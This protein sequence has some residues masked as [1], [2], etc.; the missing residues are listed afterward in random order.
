M[1]KEKIVQKRLLSVGFAIVAGVGG[2]LSSR[3]CG[4]QEQQGKVVLVREG[5]T[6]V[7][8]PYAPNI[9]R[10]TL[11]TLYDRA[12]AG[13]GY[14]F[15]A[16][17]AAGGW[18]NE[19]SGDA[20]VYRSSRLTVSI[21][22]PRQNMRPIGPSQKAIGD[23][24]GSSGS[25]RRAPTRVMV[26][27]SDGATLVNML[28]WFMNPPTHQ[29]GNTEILADQRPTD[30]PFYEVGATFA[31]PDDEHY[32]GLGQNQEGR[33][34]HRGQEVR[35]WSQYNAAGGESWCVPLLVT[36]KGYGILWDNS[37][38]TTIEPGFN[39]V[40]Q[41]SSE[42]GDRVSFFVIAGK[43]TDEIYS[44]YRLL[45][46]AT[47]LLPKGA[48]GFI[49]SKQRYSTQDE[50]LAVA[51]G[52]RERHLPADVLV[53]DWFYYTKM[54][55]MDFD[56]RYWPDPA[57]MN[58][59][60][61]SM[62]FQTMI[63]VW[64]RFVP[65]SRYYD[66][67]AKNGWLIHLADGTPM[68]TN[69]LPENH[70]GANIDTTNPDAGKFLWD[71]IHQNLIAKGFTS[72]WTDETEPDIPPNGAYLHVGPGTEYFNV[73]PLFHT[74]AVYD[75]MR[76]DMKTR[77]LILARAAYT[78][79]Q[80]NGTIF[81]SSDISPTWD[82]LKRQVP[83]GLDATASGLPYWCN[84]VGGFQGLPA[85]HHPA[86]PPLIDPSDA[87]GNVGD[88]DDYPELYVRWYEYGAFEPIFRTHGTRTYN[89][90][91]SYGKQAEPILEKYL[92]L[93]YQLMPY[94][95]SLAWK[96]YSTGAPYTRALFMNFPSD[97]KVAGLGDEYMFG[98]ALLVAPVTDQGATSRPVYLPA[99]T[100]WYNYWTNEKLH[101]GQTIEADAPIDTIPLF[102]K[103]GSILPLGEAVESTSQPQALAKI[104]IYPGSDGDFALYQ[105]DG[106]TY[107]YE[108]S[109]GQVT[110]LHWIDGQQR[111]SHSGAAAWSGPDSDLL[112]IVHVQSQ[113]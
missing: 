71:A 62:G 66:Q 95:Y 69:G 21:P 47:P 98:P 22:M 20:D 13:P 104:R 94:I 39:E 70:T 16:L 72:I 43:D 33:L 108:K 23:F 46:G 28:R 26:S 76:R 24:F 17:P 82:A 51:K 2:L 49:Q 103:A 31:S 83:A 79:A 50:V 52:Y 6:V 5:T 53:V 85:V 92:R 63:S 7:L 102:V 15:V 89:E 99:G 81:W 105:D 100:D 113:K 60:L 65:G 32:Y 44:G 36:N 87:R 41:W 73:Y 30:D 88:Y 1:V 27:T 75:G 25:P 93:R 18:S 8:E 109:G 11:S 48:Y 40:T 74:A 12:V 111:F 97:P 106:T 91:W 58:R 61:Q 19:H 42:V 4:A 80:R 112:E 37:S 67:L 59:E 78:G 56:S 9:I 57:A 101:G 35:C 55:Q 10:I 86:R 90:V 3:A 77:A 14:G 107:A 45:T 38:K 68:T 29:S 110:N 54:G 64:P 34:D 84:D 96:S